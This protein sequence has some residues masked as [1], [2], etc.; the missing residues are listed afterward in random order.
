MHGGADPGDRVEISGCDNINPEGYLTAISVFDQTGGSVGGCIR[1]CTVTDHAGGAAFGSGGWKNFAV[2]DN[3][4]SNVNTGIT[5]DTHDYRNVT[6]YGNQFVNLSQYGI[7][8]NGS[9]VYDNIA[10]HDNIFDCSPH[11]NA[12]NVL[13]TGNARVAVS[14][15]DN[16]IKQGKT[17]FPALAFGPQTS[18]MVNE[19]TISEVT[20]SDL[21]AC[22]SLEVTQ[23]HDI[24]GGAVGL[25]RNTQLSSLS[26]ATRTNQTSDASAWHAQLAE[27]FLNLPATGN[28]LEGGLDYAFAGAS[29][30]DGTDQRTCISLPDS[31]SATITIDNLGQQVQDFLATQA[32]DP[33]ALY[34]ILGGNDDLLDD[35]TAAHVS[36]VA[37][38][39][40][41]LIE[42][43]ATAGA[44][45]FLMPNAPPLGALP[46]YSG[47]SSKIVSLDAASSNYRAELASAL[48]TTEETL[49][50]Q[51]ISIRIY[52]ADIW[53]R[54]LRILAEPSKYGFTNVGNS[55][56]GNSAAH[57][58][59]YLFWDD[60]HPTKAGQLQIADEANR[61]LNASTSAF[62]QVANLSTRAFVGTSENVLIQGFMI[63]G[64]DPKIVI[65]RALGPGLASSGVAGALADPT[66]S[67]YDQSGK[68][69]AAK[70]NWRDSQQAEIASTTIAPPSNLESAIVATLPPG[71]YT[72]V[73]SRKNNGT[74]V[75][76]AEIYDLSSGANSTLANVSTRGFIGSGDNVLIGGFIVQDGASPLLV[77]RAV[78]PTLAAAGIANALPDPLLELRDGNGALIASNDNW[79]STQSEALRASGLAS[80][81]G[82]EAAIMTS[83]N[84]G[85][86]TVVVRGKDNAAGVGLVEVYRLQ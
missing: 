56:D 66:L 36:V 12:A 7:I 51:G 74:G 80:T 10:I 9:G 4:T 85:N 29:T 13:V 73:V 45:N 17:G 79:Q 52:P 19:N 49:I 46:H 21:S 25:G 28:S 16:V 39:I 59:Q 54:M 77:A 78:G 48:A 38:R 53:S 14:L 37:Q 27:N 58:D 6:I 62:G 41:A 2:A 71:S 50:A 81:D 33:A 34:V 61:V 60:I 65:L 44:R 3:Y 57:P 32:V 1:N 72:C 84:A 5:I 76:L 30:R 26:S 63:G 11:G 40:G 18:G 8:F 70:D 69:V 55:A 31:A 68:L 43:L 47:D 20:P 75:A 42:K 24:S 35:D 82:R 83:L 22:T 86:Y 67:L 64:S 15:Y 23:N